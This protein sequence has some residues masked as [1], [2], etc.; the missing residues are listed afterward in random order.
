MTSLC[1][2]PLCAGVAGFEF[3][4]YSTRPFPACSSIQLPSS[5]S[6]HNVKNGRART[7]F[8]LP[9][10][11][12]GDLV[13]LLS[14]LYRLRRVSTTVWPL[15]SAMQ[16]CVGLGWP[17]LFHS[18]I[19]THTYTDGANKTTTS[20]FSSPS[21]SS[22]CS[23][24]CCLRHDSDVILFTNEVRS[25]GPLSLS[26]S[27]L[28]S[29]HHS[30]NT[31]DFQFVAH[32]RFTATRPLPPKDEEEELL[33][34]ERRK[35][36][37]KKEKHGKDVEEE[38]ESE[39][40]PSASEIQ[41]EVTY[42]PPLR[43]FFTFDSCSTVTAD[44]HVLDLNHTHESHSQTATTTTTEVVRGEEM[45]TTSSERR[46]EKKDDC[47]ICQRDDVSRLKTA[48]QSVLSQTHRWRE[49][50]TLL[51][52]SSPS[53]LSVHLWTAPS[54][55]LNRN[56][57]FLYAYGWCGIGALSMNLYKLLPFSH[58]LAPFLFLYICLE[59]AYIR[60]KLTSFLK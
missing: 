43:S 36:K 28:S 49:Q 23:C 60:Y 39:S 12:S 15:H 21:H 16:M 7:L 40:A 27:S 50:V 56:D 17:L 9:H 52:S 20:L 47:L 1:A 44:I 46:E 11:C 4:L 26:S 24:V 8:L 38:N 18:F 13:F 42:F 25:Q 31:R 53:P 2:I 29:L 48:A 45:T 37:E 3:R 51:S 19:L 33:E 32:V 58:Q 34:L 35:K 57:M 59:T 30:L 55:E 54:L 14:L 22:T 6:C 10:S 5:R 41:E